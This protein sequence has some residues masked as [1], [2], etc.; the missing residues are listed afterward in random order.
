[1]NF[2]VVDSKLQIIYKIKIINRYYSNIIKEIELDISKDNNAFILH[3]I[4]NF[5]M[6]GDNF[7][8]LDNIKYKVTGW[9]IR[10]NNIE[11]CVVE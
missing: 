11:I 1:M 10:G 3:Q 2:K 9:I 6:Y 4:K 8:E 5:Q 7:I